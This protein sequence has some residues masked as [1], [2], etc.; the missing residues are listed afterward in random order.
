MSEM[1]INLFS[2]SDVCEEDTHPLSKIVLMATTI[3]KK[4]KE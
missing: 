3:I 2:P 4:D 1:I